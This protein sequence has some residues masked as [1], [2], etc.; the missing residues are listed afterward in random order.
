MPKPTWKEIRDTLGKQPAPPP[1]A[2]AG[3]FWP[4]LR[5]RALPQPRTDSV[6]VSPLADWALPRWVAVAACIA[7]CVAGLLHTDLGHAPTA[8]PVAGGKP[9]TIQSLAVAASHSSVMILQDEDNSGTIV[10]ITDMAD[11]SAP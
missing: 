3:Q 11:T 5:R 9:N 6:T 2:A 10:W 7:V 1:P 4:D 8:T